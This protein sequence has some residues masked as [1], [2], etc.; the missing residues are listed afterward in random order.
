MNGWKGRGV[1]TPTEERCG[2]LIDVSGLL[3][4]PS[5]R[6]ALFPFSTLPLVLLNREGLGVSPDLRGSGGF[7][8]ICNAGALGCSE[9]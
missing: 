6:S 7:P 3:L 1:R 4:H 2:I 8:R 9:C 5:P